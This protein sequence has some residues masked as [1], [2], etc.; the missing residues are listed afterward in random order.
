MSGEL[1]VLG[2]AGSLRKKSFNRALLRAAREL[3]PD[4]VTLVEHDL[5]ALPLY[6]ADLDVDGGPAEVREF[7][8]AIA[9]AD[10][11][12]IASP[13]YNYGVPGVLKNAIDWASRPGFRSVLVGKPAA[14]MGASGGAV[15]TARMQVE[16][17]HLLMGVL[18]LPFPHPDVLVG[19]AAQKFDAEL[20]LTDERTRE[21]LKKMLA[22]FV[23]F[24]RGAIAGGIAKPGP[25]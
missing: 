18:A 22:G 19:N 13:E 11:L 17:R 4:G 3:L 9:A 23:V 8:A 2:I 1:G 24:A 15:G 5:R 10:A 25:R 12:L 20:R 7:K 14:I 21:F 6:D 16:L